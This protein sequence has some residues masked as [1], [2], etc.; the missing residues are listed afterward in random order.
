[1]RCERLPSGQLCDFSSRGGG[2]DDAICRQF[3]AGQLY[4]NFYIY[5]NRFNVVTQTN[6]A[7]LGRGGG[8]HHALMKRI[9]GLALRDIVWRLGAY[10]KLCWRS[11]DIDKFLF[12]PGFIHN[13]IGGHAV[14]RPTD[15]FGNGQINFRCVFTMAERRQRRQRGECVS[16]TWWCRSINIYGETMCVTHARVVWVRTSDK[17]T[18]SWRCG[19]G[20]E[21]GHHMR[22]HFSSGPF[23]FPSHGH[24]LSVT[25]RIA[26]VRALMLEDAMC[27]G[28]P[29]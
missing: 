12:I 25:H 23:P 18:C 19:G 14:A 7:R 28:R 24:T 5:R 17:M 8:A 27:G 21:W 20:G 3:R 16:H 6:R 13:I 26:L 11:T 22:T 2:D 15:R 9:S 10:N 29:H 4:C 1:M